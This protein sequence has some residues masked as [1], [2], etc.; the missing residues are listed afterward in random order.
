MG[1]Q[2]LDCTCKGFTPFAKSDQ[3]GCYPVADSVAAESVLASGV[4]K[5]GYKGRLEGRGRHTELGKRMK[6][7]AL[8]YRQISFEQ[9][10][11]PHPIE[12]VQNAKVLCIVSLPSP[13]S[14]PTRP[15][16]ET[17]RNW[18]HGN[19][20]ER[21]A[22]HGPSR[23]E[24][25]M[26]QIMALH[27][28]IQAVIQRI[29]EKERAMK[30][31]R[32]H[33]V[34]SIRP[35]N[36]MIAERLLEKVESLRNQA[37]REGLGTGRLPIKLMAM[38]KVLQMECKVL[39]NSLL[40][41]GNQDGSQ[42]AKGVAEAI[43]GVTLPDDKPSTSERVEVTSSKFGGGRGPGVGISHVSGYQFHVNGRAMNG[44]PATDF[45]ANG[46]MNGFHANG[47][48]NG[49]LANGSANSVNG[50]ESVI[51]GIPSYQPS[52]PLSSEIFEKQKTASPATSLTDEATTTVVGAAQSQTW[53]SKMLAG[54]IGPGMGTG[55]G[56]A[57]TGGPGANGR[58]AIDGVPGGGLITK[59]MPNSFE[60]ERGEVSGSAR[61]DTSIWG[62]WD[63]VKEI[64]DWWDHETETHHRA[65]SLRS[66]E[67]ERKA[68][69]MHTMDMA[70]R[71]GEMERLKKELVRMHKDM[72]VLRQ[73]ETARVSA[74]EGKLKT[75]E[76]ELAKR[77]PLHVHEDMV[78]KLKGPLLEA[79]AKV[80]ALNNELKEKEVVLSTLK[81]DMAV[82]PMQ[83]VMG[84]AGGAAERTMTFLEKELAQASEQ[85][86]SFASE[87]E[88]RERALVQ[89]HEDW[90]RERNSLKPEPT[91]IGAAFAWVAAVVVTGV[92]A[93]TF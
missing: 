73:A 8:G 14:S 72:E 59:G 89:R 80:V 24:D 87:L 75:L 35:G 38:L 6:N 63:R 70:M 36:R 84:L 41:T 12:K 58:G 34:H 28:N 46:T 5:H 93:I 27:E 64:N 83:Q 21:P 47:S 1:S 29:T 85:A 48:S 20:T 77:I 33:E 57:A 66:A 19:L 18:L 10:R 45:Q 43:L 65:E 25:S 26:A 67:L 42:A 44:K 16:T 78:R 74:M 9:A 49:A 40:Q 79:R 54:S 55:N 60:K 13:S 50:N 90:A 53:L 52:M 69:V 92:I 51:P 3:L 91:G 22:R 37:H 2:L 15:G 56:K 81:Q 30:G 62:G 82:D 17:P 4:A 7:E 31:G 11:R 76:R 32:M 86:K 61:G 23:T 88:R 68:A 71:E 39:E